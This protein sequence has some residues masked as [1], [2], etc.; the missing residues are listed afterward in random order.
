ML[1]FLRIILLFSFSSYIYSCL[2]SLEPD[3]KG[4]T[5]DRVLSL[6]NCY[7]FSYTFN[8]G[9]ILP[10]NYFAKSLSNSLKLPIKAAPPT[11]N[12]IDTENKYRNHLFDQAMQEF[13]DCIQFISAPMLKRVNRKKQINLKNFFKNS[14]DKY[15][16]FLSEFFNALDCPCSKKTVMKLP[17]I[18]SI[19][20][21]TPTSYE[22]KFVLKP[23]WQDPNFKK[24]IHEKLKLFLSSTKE[25]DLPENSFNIAIHFRHG[26]AFDPPSVKQQHSLRFLPKSFYTSTLPKI[27]KFIPKQVPVFIGIFTDCNDPSLT[28]SFIQSITNVSDNR[29]KIEL[30]ADENDLFHDMVIMSKFDFIIRPISS[31]SI[32]SEHLGDFV[33]VCTVQVQGKNTVT[34]PSGLKAL[35]HFD[36]EK[37]QKRINDL[38]L[39]LAGLTH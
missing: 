2:P 34:L 26:G 3:A 23:D 30:L 10:K 1:F 15:A 31:F 17:N 25:T 11:L 4:R 9:V 7:Y 8:S 5:G 21:S 27:L 28:A 39:I 36:H 29:A 38:L 19:L 12:Q 20:I 22:N 32:A 37:F 13:K 6:F 18:A 35:I 24:Y 33:G 16:N 14:I